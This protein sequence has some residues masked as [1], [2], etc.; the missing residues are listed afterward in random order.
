MSELNHTKSILPYK[1]ILELFE[2]RYRDADADL[3]TTILDEISTEIENEAEG[4]GATV[5]KE[6]ALK[7]VCRMFVLQYY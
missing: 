3:R 6:E 1:A 2:E 7:K 5:A 4:N